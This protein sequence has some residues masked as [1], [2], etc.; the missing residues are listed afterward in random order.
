MKKKTLNELIS[1]KTTKMRD[2]DDCVHAA[3][4]VVHRN[5]PRLSHYERGELKQY[6]TKYRA[7][8]VS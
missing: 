8:Y 2:D 5:E 4:V 6:N 7:Q 1:N 3:A